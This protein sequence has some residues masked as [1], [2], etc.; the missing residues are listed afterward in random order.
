MLMTPKRLVRQGRE[1][2]VTLLLCCC[3]T[4]DVVFP[5]SDWVANA[6]P[7]SNDPSLKTFRGILDDGMIRYHNRFNFSTRVGTHTL[8]EM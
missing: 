2:E 4:R 6:D 3:E 8:I 1:V 5:P 7:L